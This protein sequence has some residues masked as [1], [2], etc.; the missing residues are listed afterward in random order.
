MIEGYIKLTSLVLCFCLFPIL[1]SLLVL[2]ILIPFCILSHFSLCPLSYVSLSL[3]VLMPFNSGDL[4]KEMQ[5][6]S[7]NLL[8]FIFPTLFQALG[9]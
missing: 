4:E 3:P 9:L 5:A 7:I 2:L 1:F 8:L 6:T